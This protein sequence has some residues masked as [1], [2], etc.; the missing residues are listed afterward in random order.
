MKNIDYSFV[1]P[2]FILT[3]PSLGTQAF[4]AL[5]SYREKYDGRGA[6]ILGA[7]VIFNFNEKASIAVIG[8]N[9]L[10]MTYANRPAMLGEPINFSARF[11][12]RFKGKKKE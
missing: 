12:Y 4:S 10:N 3:E 6:T 11:T 5:K 9:L 1:S 7:R 2:L 8:D